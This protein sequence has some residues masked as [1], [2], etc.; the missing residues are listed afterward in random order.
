MAGD[1]MRFVRSYRGQDIEAQLSRLGDA[2]EINLF[3]GDAPHIG[4]V[5]IVDTLGELTITEF[6]QHREGVLCLRW[7]TAI[8][9]LGI[10]PA[11]VCSG[12]HYDNA[13]SEEISDILRLCDELLGEVLSELKADLEM[14]RNV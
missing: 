4:A 14:K 10:S 6:P 9:E 5:G 3:G 7:C 13:I 2:L 12:I 11:V 8:S 1:V